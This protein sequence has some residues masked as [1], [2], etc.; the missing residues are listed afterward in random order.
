MSMKK[1]NLLKWGF[2]CLFCMLTTIGWAASVEVNDQTTCYFTSGSPTNTTDFTIGS[3]S[4]TTNGGHGY[5]TINGTTYSDC[6]KMGSSQT[7][8][9]TTTED[10][11]VL[12]LVF[13]EGSTHDFY[14]YSGSTSDENPTE[15]TSDNNVIVYT[16]GTAGTYVLARK[17][18]EQY[19]F[20]IGLSPE[21]T[22]SYYA[23]SFDPD[24]LKSNKDSNTSVESLSSITVACSGTSTDISYNTGSIS[25]Q[26]DDAD[27]TSVT[28]SWN[29][30]TNAIELS[31]NGLTEEGTYTITI[32]ASYFTLG[33][34]GSNS[35]I[36]LTYDVE[37]PVTHEETNVAWWDWQNDLPSGI[38][39]GTNI[40]SATGTVESTL[41]G[42][43]MYVDATNS[44]KLSSSGRNDNEC[45]MNANTILQIPVGA[46]SDVIT[47]VAA[48]NGGYTIGSTTG[49][50][51]LEQTYN[52]SDEEVA[53]GY[54]VM[55]A[56]NS[57]AA[58]YLYYIKVEYTDETEVAKVIANSKTY[59]EANWDWANSNPSSITSVDIEGTTGYV[60]SDVDGIQMY[61]NA[62][63]G[64][65]LRGGDGSAAFG[66]GTILRV[67][68]VN[69]GDKVTV[70]GYV[71]NSQTGL[72]YTICGGDTIC[73]V[74]DENPYTY[75]ATQDDVD[76]G[77]VQIEAVDDGEITFN[78]IY[79]VKVTFATTITGATIANSIDM[80][81]I[82]AAT[83]DYS[84][85]P[86]AVVIEITSKSDDLNQS[87]LSNLSD[88]DLTGDVASSITV[89][90]ENL[91]QYSGAGIYLD[92]T[93]PI[94][95]DGDTSVGH[96][97]SGWF[98]ADT[99]EDEEATTYTWTCGWGYELE[100]GVTY[101]FTITPMAEYNNST[102]EAI[103]DP[104]TFTIEGAATTNSVGM[105]A[106]PEDG[107]T[108]KSGSD[109]TITLT[110]DSAVKVTSAKMSLGAESDDI[111]VT[112]QQEASQT[113]T[114]TIT[115]EQ[116]NTILNQ[117]GG[118]LT[119]M[120]YAE[121][122][123]G[124]TVCDE[125]GTEFFQISYTV[126]EGT[127]E[128]A[129][130]DL[131]YYPTSGSSIYN[132]LSSI[133]V[134]YK[135]SSSDYADDASVYL[136]AGSNNAAKVT[137]ENGDEVTDGEGNVIT[138]SLDSGDEYNEC[139]IT[140]SSALTEGSY[141]IVLDGQN[142]ENG[143]AFNVSVAESDYED[144]TTV[145][146]NAETTL[147]YTVT[148]TLSMSLESDDLDQASAADLSQVDEIYVET[149]SLE[150]LYLTITVTDTPDEGEATSETYDMTYEES[151]NDYV[152]SCEEG[153]IVLYSGHSYSLSVNAYSD[154]AK[155]DLIGTLDLYTLTG[156]TTEPSENPTTFTMEVLPTPDNAEF[157]SGVEGSLIVNCSDYVTVEATIDGN[158][159]TA[160]VTEYAETSGELS[161]G[162]TL[163][164][165]AETMTSY[166]G[167]SFEITIVA[168][169]GDDET[170]E[171]TY[172]YS[173]AS[174]NGSVEGNEGTVNSTYTYTTTPENNSTIS[175]E[176]GVSDIVIIYDTTVDG[177]WDGEFG[178]DE[179]LETSVIVYNADNEVAASVEEWQFDEYEEYDEDGV[180][181]VV[182]YTFHLNSTI[183][184]NGTYHFTIPEGAFLLGADQS[185]VSEKIEVTFNIAD[186]SGING[187]TLKAGVDDKFY[188]L[189]GQRVTS[190]RNGVYILNGKKV[191]IK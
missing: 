185:I 40:Q 18:S 13:N 71:W 188:N 125:D 182:G 35:A 180:P 163:T 108:I 55:T 11:T 52:P 169:N 78:Y 89:T 7:I 109:Q 111:A 104:V 3:G 178:Y 96:L 36:T 79:S 8:T 82:A 117:R 136:N 46:T 171:A 41:E 90:A 37:E 61:V 120:I 149:N 186:A 70:N 45:Q 158:A 20:Y 42:I 112:E 53:T 28:A 183:T 133:T 95:G 51:A 83:P 137:D 139:V 147:T 84:T 148:N 166:A 59:T 121:D 76:N 184:T 16:I 170:V 138:A 172:T 6:I 105:T 43:T 191:L 168:T 131:K 119:L 74:T 56:T 81:A 30:S 49:V 62:P 1:F 66:T 160:T 162:W 5:A 19:L 65:V 159:V 141:Q 165:P 87:T 58:V 64:Q 15:L 29:S 189:N 124:N 88:G 86:D 68:V 99:N 173:V 175:N 54:V 67:P 150:E 144:E 72:C 152:W 2:L 116:L 60:D 10:N 167:N 47:I 38:Y 122:A 69:V 110:F 98:E 92:I 126:E 48:K 134:T 127:E 161:K 100:N 26:K 97:T 142:G 106:D 101:T 32:P 12:T 164:I 156:T 73:A 130:V 132:S 187:I 17:S 155:T 39:S 128:I 50:T 63:S 103:G 177:N 85:E 4:Y 34:D 179:F 77:F 135:Y 102:S 140:F 143:A 146:V 94:E 157:T 113:W 91:E 93:Y 27:Y 107:E 57:D 23:L 21:S 22:A 25:I 44:G 174:S 151:D 145:G 153:A 75:T 115:S 114:L 24:G 123:D 118:S 154:E 181:T 9:F 14:L 80:S 33:T 190:P 176:V 129:E 31:G